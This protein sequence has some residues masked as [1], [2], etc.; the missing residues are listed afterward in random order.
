MFLSEEDGSV[1][2]GLASH[3]P[4]PV[5]QAIAR[6]AASGSQYRERT[7]DG[8]GIVTGSGGGTSALPCALSAYVRMFVFVGPGPE[9]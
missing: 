4:T 5:A 9:G 8:E 7:G 6:T 2:T 1:A 3:F